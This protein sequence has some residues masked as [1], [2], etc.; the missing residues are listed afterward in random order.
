VLDGLMEPGTLQLDRWRSMTPDRYETEFSMHRGHTPSY[1]GP[2]LSAF[3][4]LHRETTRYRTPITGLYLSGAGTFPGAGVFGASGRNAAD[5]VAHDLRANGRSLASLG[6]TIT[7]R[8]RS[9]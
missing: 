7:S 2:P 4:G 3:L 6:R 1:A 5:A 8:L 9:R